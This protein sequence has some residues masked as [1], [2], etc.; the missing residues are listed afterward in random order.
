VLVAPPVLTRNAFLGGDI[1]CE[2]AEGLGACFY[3]SSDPPS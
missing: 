2:A 1:R 3:F